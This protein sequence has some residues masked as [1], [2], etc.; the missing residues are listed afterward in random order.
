MRKSIVAS[1][2]AILV[3]GGFGFFGAFANADTSFSN[4]WVR[5]NGFINEWDNSPVS[6]QLSASAMVW[7][8]NGTTHQWASVNAM[9]INATPGYVQPMY[10]DSWLNVTQDVSGTFSFSYYITRLVNTTAV[11]VTAG[12]SIS[13]LWNVSEITTTITINVTAHDWCSKLV[14]FSRTVTQIVGLAPGE[15]TANTTTIITPSFVLS[16]NFELNITGIP[17]LSGWAFVMHMR[18]YEINFFDVMNNGDSP[19]DIH[20]L[21]KVARSYG[22]VVGMSGY[23][24]NLD[25][26]L[27]GQI[28]LADLTTIAANIQG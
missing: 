10:G 22:A 21:V 9:W 26:N 5:L 18:S 2:L 17:V 25:F 8:K 27:D 11:N 7:S 23:D 15:L 19:V 3:I 13:G 20:D 4:T 12:L 6:G 16:P 28:G 24:F 14:S 1:V